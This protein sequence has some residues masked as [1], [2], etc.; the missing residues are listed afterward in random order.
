M[1][2]GIMGAGSLGTILGAYLNKGGLAV[3]LIDANKAHV[4]ALNE[5]GARVI[6]KSDFTVPVHAL[7]PENMEGIYDLIIYMVKQTYNDTALKQIL[8]HLG[9][10]SMVLTLQNGMPELEVSEYVGKERTIGGMVGWGA[11]WI[12][13]GVS[14]CTSPESRREFN[15]GEM[16]GK[17]T[18]RILE[19]QKILSLMCHTEVTNNLMGGRWYKLH[20]NAALSGMSAVCGCTFGELFQNERSFRCVQL[21]GNETIQAAYASGVT[22]DVVAGFDKNPLAFQDEAGLQATRE[23]YLKRWGSSLLKASMLQDLEK[24]KKC[25]VD[26]IDGVVAKV[27]RQVGVPTPVT[28]QVIAIIKGCEEGKY[29][30]SMDNLDLFDPE[31]FTKPYEAPAR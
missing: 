2:I 23:I 11:T 30:P 19:L 24:G 9:P 14:E 3:D 7:L 18:P 13:P 4:D 22:L 16:D 12:G 8:P 25:E 10:E 15:I 5:K 29:K 20:T 21:V 6:G 17:I 26:G 1:R 28:D 27:G 31:I